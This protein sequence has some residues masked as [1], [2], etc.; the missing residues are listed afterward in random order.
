MVL[1][2]KRKLTLRKLTARGKR[3]RDA[4][5]GAGG[6]VGALIGIPLGAPGIVVGGIVGAAIANTETRKERLRRKK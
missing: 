5:L 4:R 6:T 3:L 2:R 1:R